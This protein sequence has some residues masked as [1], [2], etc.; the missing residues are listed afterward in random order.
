MAS[1]YST[2]TRAISATS[3]FAWAKLTGTRKNRKPLSAILEGTAAN[4]ISTLKR[5]LRS[6]RNDRP[7]PA[8]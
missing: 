7:R 4:S 6:S 1:G 8:S 3:H 2:M 5:Q